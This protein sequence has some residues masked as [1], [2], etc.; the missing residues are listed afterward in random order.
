MKCLSPP[1]PRGGDK[2]LLKNDGSLWGMGGTIEG[3]WAMHR[4]GS[5]TG[6]MVEID[7]DATD[8][9][10]NGN[11]G[12]VNGASLNDRHGQASKAYS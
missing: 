12:T 9:S 10:G 3:N 2:L 11:D 4:A 6:R 1:L 5:G 8:S 7:G